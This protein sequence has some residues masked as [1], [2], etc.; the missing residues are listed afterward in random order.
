[1][2]DNATLPPEIDLDSLFHRKSLFDSI[3]KLDKAGFEIVR[4]SKDRVTVFGH[5]S[6]PGY[7][8][9]KFLRTVEHSPEKQRTS[10]QKRVRGARDLRTHLDALSIH[11]IVVPRKW[12]CELPP[13]FRRHEKLDHVVVVEKCDLL[14]RDRIK[15]RY[16]ALSKEVVRDFCTI[17]FTFEG[18]DFSLRNWPFT[19]EGKIA[20]IDTRCL[21]RITKDMAFRRMS[22]Q[23]Y[24]EKKL[25]TSKSQR[26]A[27]SLW[28]EVKEECRDL[29][30]KV[31]P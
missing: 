28:D 5:A 4:G 19:T 30:R 1:M 12:L 2:S 8:F 24:V 11:S 15:K 23:K 29:L 27:M 25:L 16:R 9:K 7:L 26:Y 14:E 13:R 18:V 10:Y 3:E 6:A 20:C 21:K 31:E 17:F 22:Y